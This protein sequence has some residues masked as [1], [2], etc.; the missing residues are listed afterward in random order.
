MKLLTEAI[1]AK[2]P[3][4]G[5]TN[6]GDA[7]VKFFN[8]TGAGTWFASEFDG[9]DTFFGWAMI[10]PGC[11]EYGYFSLSELASFK[12]QFGLGIERD[13]YFEQTPMAEAIKE[14]DE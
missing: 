10:L 8:P 1:K 6:G 13:L 12:G 5:T 2:L 14:Y 7:I 3:K 9:E 4:L 11:G